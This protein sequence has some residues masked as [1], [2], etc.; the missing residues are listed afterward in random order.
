MKE[1][2]MK[3]YAL[4]AVL[5]AL[6]GLAGVTVG[7]SGAFASH[8][9]EL[10]RA[11][12]IVESPT[13]EPTCVAAWSIVE[14]PTLGYEVSELYGVKALAANDVWAVGSYISST[15]SATP[16]AFPGTPFP[17]TST[18]GAVT[19]TP[20]AAVGTLGNSRPAYDLHK[21]HGKRSPDQPGSPEQTLA[22]HWDGTQ[23]TVVH[24]PDGNEEDDNYLM[25]VDGIATNDV[26][27]AG[28]YISSLGLA[29]TLIEHWDGSAWTISPSANAGPYQDNQLFGIQV[30][31][32]NDVWAVGAH[33]N[34]AGIFQTL[35][36]HWDGSAWSV[37]SSPNS[38][39]YNNVLR[40]LAVVSASDIWAVGY[41]DD[42]AAVH[43]RSLAMHWDGAAWT[44]V[45]VPAVGSGYNVLNSVDADAPN[46]VWAVGNYSTLGGGNRL[47]A[48]HWDGSS[49]TVTPFPSLDADF[50]T[51]L[52]VDILSPADVWAVGSAQYY[53]TYSSTALAVHWDGTEWRQVR[54][55]STTS[56]AYPSLYSVSAL[57]SQDAWAVG[58]YGGY[59]GLPGAPLAEHF[60]TECVQPTCQIRFSDVHE[61]DYFYFPVRYLYCHQVISGYADG[62]FRPGNNVTRGQ[63]T[64]IMVAVEGWTLVNPQFSH[65]SDVP[66]WDPFYQYIETAYEHGVISGYAD[67]TFRPGNNV[68]RGQLSK[69]VV[70]SQQWQIDVSGAPHFVDVPPNNP[71]YGEIET[72]YN[73]GVISGYADGT[74]RPGNPATRGQ[75]SKIVFEAVALP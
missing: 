39:Q 51:L 48:M 16:T 56:H 49:W 52:G 59:Y 67:G 42:Q 21:S 43:S 29:Q 37:V 75:V 73:H 20:G 25:A 19:Q 26:W 57:N 66:P 41:Y 35:I 71:F 70:L 68:T 28:Y 24:S 69:I 15:T 47:L 3:R 63:L 18:P 32:A 8:R 1:G 36:E 27:A 44:L 34:D 30:V 74:F 54:M 10:S 23:W 60:S 40:D 50:S 55:P 62:T 4:V 65:F 31:S 33:S 17:P 58:V 45:P 46:D 61:S 64:K 22:T 12:R 14:T 6:L 2:V 38:G 72:M 7:S 53:Y 9:A 13:P 5:F 11:V